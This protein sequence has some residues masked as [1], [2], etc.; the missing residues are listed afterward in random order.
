MKE[1]LVVGRKQRD[2]NSFDSFC[3]VEETRPFL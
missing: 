3:F 1:M 2:S